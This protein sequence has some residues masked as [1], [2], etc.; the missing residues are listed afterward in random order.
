MHPLSRIRE[1]AVQPLQDRYTRTLEALRHEERLLMG[2]VALILLAVLVLF[3][4]AVSALGNPAFRPLLTALN[5]TGILL[6][7][8]MMWS[9]RRLLRRIRARQRA[10]R[11][12][13]TQL[14]LPALQESAALDSRSLRLLFGAL[15]ILLLGGWILHL[16]LLWSL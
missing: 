2:C 4:P 11:E 14:C 16:I 6:T 9:A 7:L 12:I 13:E 5:L 1:P 8:L 15:F 10:C 3:I